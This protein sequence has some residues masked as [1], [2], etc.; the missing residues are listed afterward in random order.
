[1]FSITERRASDL[2]SWK[3]RTIPSRATLWAGTPARLGRPRT[4]SARV[5][6]VEAGEQVEQ[7]RLAGAVRTDQGGDGAPLDLEVVDVDRDEAAEPAGD[8]VGHED[9]I[10]LGDPRLGPGPAKASRRTECRVGASAPDTD[11]HLP[12]VADDALGPEDHEQ[13]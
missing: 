3:V 1:M 7:R 2:V 9:R 13:P 10:G 8:A 11:R 6:L 4:A 5:G 12:L